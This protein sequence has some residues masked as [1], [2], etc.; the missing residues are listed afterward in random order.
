V[1]LPIRAVKTSGY[2][3][4]G[5][6]PFGHK[7]T[8]QPSVTTILKAENKPA[9]PQWS[10]DQTAAIA[11]ANAERLLGMSDQKAWGFL[12]YVW[13]KEPADAFSSELDLSAYHGKVLQDSSELGD[14]VHEWIEADLFGTPFPDVRNRNSAFWEC[15]AQWNDFKS[16]H[17]IIPHRTEITVW[18]GTAG[19]GYGGT[20]DLLIEVDGK[21]MLIDIKTSRGLYSSTWMQLAALYSAPY[22]LEADPTVK[23]PKDGEDRLLA[24]WQLPIEGM[25]VIHVRPT[26]DK[27]PAFCELV[28]YPTKPGQS[29]QEA[30][31]E[32]H[33][34]FMGLRQYTEMIKQQGGTF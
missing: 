19:S 10:A 6:R 33:K 23:D 9:L 1:T 29:W 17:T 5:Y 11:V 26:D 21:L 20:F 12:R 8:T 28:P 13:K 4:R 25:A 22:L 27:G 31:A 18:D 34:G 32:V 2:G 14:A 24:G 7:V 3:G 16:R 30:A 15:V